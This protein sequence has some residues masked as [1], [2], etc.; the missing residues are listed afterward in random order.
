[1]L[2][3][4]AL[5]ASDD[6]ASSLVPPIVAPYDIHTFVV[7]ALDVAPSHGAALGDPRHPWCNSV[8]PKVRE[9][10]KDQRI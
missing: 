5:D 8:T 9:K 6:D 4:H 10:S 3:T 2:L 1:M 7:H